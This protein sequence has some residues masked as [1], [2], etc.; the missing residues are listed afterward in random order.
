VF[1]EPLVTRRLSLMNRRWLISR[2]NSEYVNYLSKA[3]SL[4]PIFA[5]VLIN[6]GIKT[7]GDIADFLNP[8]LTNLSDP[9]ELPDMKTAVERIKI[10]Q[11]RNER[12]LVHGDYDTDGLTATAILVQALKSAGVDANYFI[13]NRM[14]DGYGFNPPAVALAKKIGARII[15]TV[16]CGIASFEAARSAKEQGIDLIVTDHHEPSIKNAEIKARGSERKNEADDF[17]LP[18]AIAIVNPKLNRRNPKLSTLSGAGIAFKVAQ[19]LG[20]DGTLPFSSDDA[21]RLLDL[22]ALGT[23]AD[24]VPLVGE[25]RTIT[26]EGLKCIQEAD[27]PGIRALISVSGLGERTI[28]SGLLSFTIVPRINAS[29][30]IGDSAD[31][32]VLLLSDST[33][34]TFSLAEKLDRTNT[35]RQRIEEEV[36][37]EALSQLNKKGYD[38]AIVLFGEDWHIGV[39]G[40]VASRI[41]EKFNRP[42][43][44][45]TMEDNV[46]KGSVR[47]IPSFDVYSGL[48]S[49][50]DVLISFGGHRQAAGVKLEAADILRFEE[51][52][53]EVVKGT[54]Q[55]EDFLPTIEIDSEVALSSVNASLIR[56]FSM[57]EP[58][59][60]GNRDPI[61]GARRLVFQNQR[62]VGSKHLKLRMRQRSLSMDAI[63]FD[64]GNFL[65][66]LDSLTLLDAAFTPVMNEWNNN[67]H[68]QLTLKAIRP[69]D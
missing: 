59:G 58:V 44:V 62:V 7:P 69:S 31:V 53:N 45:F 27:R 66:R 1:F 42:T 67:K 41:A 64:M 32:I 60:A 40:I 22:A 14:S 13:P 34:E 15:V 23:V 26:K 54:L 37:Q 46:A 49:C 55:R 33:D 4:S 9:F 12:I 5:R 57:L 65:E 50:S 43:F 38:S 2:T 18:E 36:Y 51:R 63:G 29:G 68:I 10:A 21:M 24:V 8:G 35:E 6:R 48:S 3:A 16:D 30:R 20:A 39:I 28:K 61:L 25:N 19:A 52:M 47:S 11:R 17:E 56:E